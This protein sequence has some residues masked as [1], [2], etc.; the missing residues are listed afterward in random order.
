MVFNSIG[1]AGLFSS[2]RASW[3]HLSRT[4]RGDHGEPMPPPDDKKGAVTG[5]VI[6]KG[7]SE[8][9]AAEKPEVNPPAQTEARPKPYDERP[10]VWCNR[11]ALEKIQRHAGNGPD[12]SYLIAAYIA[13]CRLSSEA[14]NTTL[15]RKPIKVIAGMIGLR[16]RKTQ[17]LLAALEK[18][19]EVIQTL[20][21]TIGDVDG[22]VYRIIPMRHPVH[23]RAG[24]DMH[25][26]AGDPCTKSKS[27]HADSPKRKKLKK[28]SRQRLTPSSISV[29][30]KNRHASKAALSLGGSAALKQPITKKGKKKIDPRIERFFNIKAYRAMAERFSVDPDDQRYPPVKAILDSLTSEPCVGCGKPT[31]HFRI[32]GKDREPFTGP[33]VCNRCSWT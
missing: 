1:E 32:E 22:Q 24:V 33:V 7:R 2:A 11:L 16:Y 29:P 17:L 15:V 30:N 8:T 5:A 19:V 25:N 27:N 14:G 18:E 3:S 31:E 6:E 23:P 9:V 26:G 28:V 21:T 13:L 10:Y 12:V 4:P 20:P